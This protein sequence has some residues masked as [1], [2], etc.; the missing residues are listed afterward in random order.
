MIKDVLVSQNRWL[1]MNLDK[2]EGTIAQATLPPEL[3]PYHTSILAKCRS[4][5]AVLLQNVSDLHLLVTTLNEEILSNTQ[6][7][8]RYM[9]LLSSRLAYPIL[10]ASEA[11]RLSLRVIGWMHQQHPET[12]QVPPAFCDGLTAVWPF[13]PPIY[14]LPCLDRQPLHFGTIF[15]PL[16]R[17][18]SVRPLWM[19]GIP[20][21][22]NYSVM[23]LDS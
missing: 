17:A 7:A 19:Y 12:E 18:S 10:R 16:S 15:M 22:R 4:L 3:M 2:L 21:C 14:F 13:D 20:G 8:T 5:R 11:D 23:R 6:A 9:H 1:L